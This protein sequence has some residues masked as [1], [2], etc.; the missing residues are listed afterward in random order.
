M[1]FEEYVIKNNLGTIENGVRFAELTTIGC[2]GKIRTL[3]TPKKF[4]GLTSSLSVYWRAWAFF[5]LLGNGSNVLASDREYTGI[6]IQLKKLPYS[7]S[8][9]DNIL[10]CSA[11]YPTSKL[12]Y[13]LALEE[14]GDLSFLGGIPGLLGGAIY[15]NSGAY[16]EDIQKH[17][18]DV[19]YI[20]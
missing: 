20:K 3:Y 18:I 1:S 11:F 6:V 16:K 12:A 8:I 15:N 5:L 17:L 14:W 10:T 9:E 4:R 2:G 13:D 7:Y 19:T